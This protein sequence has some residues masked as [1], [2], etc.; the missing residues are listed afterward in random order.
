MMSESFGVFTPFRSPMLSVW[1]IHSPSPCFTMAHRT[2][3]KRS[4]CKSCRK[5]LT[6][7]LGSLWSMCSSSWLQTKYYSFVFFCKYNSVILGFCYRELG[8]KQPIY[9]PTACYGHFGREE[10][11]WEKPK[12]LVFWVLGVAHIPV[13]K[14]SRDQFDSLTP[15]YLNTAAKVKTW[16]S[17]LCHLLISFLK[18]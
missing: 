4:C 6:S 15:Y 5:T 3:T 9:Q 16:M 11:P 7:G 14:Q 12:S 1:A 10:F 8:L 18:L 17:F 2:G 13:I